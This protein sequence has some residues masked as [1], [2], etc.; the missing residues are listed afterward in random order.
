MLPVSTNKQ[1]LEQF[2]EAIYKDIVTEHLAQGQRASGKTL[3]SLEISIGENKGSLSG[4][5][6][7]GVLEDGRKAGK[8]PPV[9]KIEQWIKD[10]GIIPKGK[11]TTL[12]LAFIFA[13]KISIE[14]TI[15]SQKG[16][17]SGVLSKA[18]NQGRIDSLI[19]SLADKYQADAMSDVLNVY[20]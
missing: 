3:E 7:I 12:Q 4:A 1:I 16:G 17:N 2:F 15:L 14:G 13:R 11:T 6:Y 10:K 18:I 8:F 5:E 9:N 19:E 20:K